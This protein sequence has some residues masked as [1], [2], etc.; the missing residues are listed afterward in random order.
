MNDRPR[1]RSAPFQRRLWLFSFILGFL[2]ACQMA[3]FKTPTAF[4]PPSPTQISTM[5]PTLLSDISSMNARLGR[6]V[7]LSA[8]EAPNE[9]EWGVILQAEYFQK[10]AAA[11]FTSVRLPVRFSAHASVEPPYTISPDFL[12]RVDWAVQQALENNLAIVIDMHHYLEMMSEPV[13]QKE[14][15]LALWAQ[16]AEHYRDYPPE[17][18]FEL[19]NEP[20]QALTA[21]LWNEII[22]EALTVIRR[23]NPTRPMIVGPVNW[24]AHD[25]L[26]DL[27]LPQNDQYLIVT[28]HYYLPFPFTHQG[29]EWVEGSD[30][31]LGTT[32]N[33]S[34]EEQQAIQADFAEVAAWAREENR[35]IYL[36][37]FGAY[38]KADMASRQR[39]TNFVARQ[40]EANGFSWSYWEFCAGFG[41]YDPRQHTW[42]TDLL[43]ALLPTSM[44]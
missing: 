3:S 35:P 36:G 1:S 7:N 25:S 29:A 14:R 6:G 42:R 13:Q 4:P 32:W 8:L 39:W 20:N 43:Q 12:A 11:G 23:T 26:V 21:S 10:I 22:A 27:R 18:M 38:Q 37:E 44:P 40:A 19:L 15:F 2:A 33:G 5:T 28:F 24:N 34:A 41:I 9:G 16:I 30:A 17:V 31:W